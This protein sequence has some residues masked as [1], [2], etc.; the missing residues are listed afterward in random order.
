MVQ[1]QVDIGLLP[2]GVQQQTLQVGAVDSGVGCAVA[3]RDVGTQ[4]HVGQLG[5]AARA[6]HRDALGEGSHSLQGVPQ[7]P[8]LQAAHDVGAELHA[9][10][11][12]GEGRCAL[13][14]AHVPAGAG[15]AQGGGQATDAA[16]GDQ[17]LFLQHGAIVTPCPACPEASR[18]TRRHHCVS[19]W[20]STYGRMPPAR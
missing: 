13:V 5:A 16:A 8:G 19:S 1:A 11:D 15:A 3:L 7:A 17:D 14:Q 20:R 2:G 9:G 12:L 6:A 10:A 18:H 4:A